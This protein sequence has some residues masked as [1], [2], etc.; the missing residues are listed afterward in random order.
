MQEFYHIAQ[1]KS[2]KV[3]TFVLH[4]ERALKAIKQQYLYAMTKEEGHRH[5]KDCLFHGLK[6][7]RCNALCYLY[8]K[9]DSQYSQLVISLRKA[10][11]DTLQSSVSEAR[12]KSAVSRGRYRFGRD[13]GQF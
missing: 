13:R 7:N 11:T 3:Q 4:L 12:A 2:E 8:D 1:G 9:P 5:L 10:E 6:P